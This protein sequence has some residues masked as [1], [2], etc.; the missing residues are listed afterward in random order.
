MT[1]ARLKELFKYDEK[2]GVFTRIKHIPHSSVTIGDELSSITDRGYVQA[3]IDGKQHKVHRL[4]WIYVYGYTPINLDHINHIRND[5]R[6]CNLREASQ[7]QNSRNM[8]NTNNKTGVMGVAVSGKKY[9]AKIKVDGK[10][11]HLGTFD[12][13]AKAEVARKKADVAYGFHQNHGAKKIGL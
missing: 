13:V 2:T 8:A 11:I 9:S 3:Y 6:I 7:K 4:A 10:Q 12:T 1:Q 5:N